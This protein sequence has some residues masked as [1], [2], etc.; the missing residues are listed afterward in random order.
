MIGDKLNRWVFVSAVTVGV[1]TCRLKKFK[2]S[3][4]ILCGRKWSLQLN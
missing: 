4:G 1:G 3:R 2:E